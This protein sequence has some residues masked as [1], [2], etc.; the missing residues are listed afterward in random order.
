MDS[1]SRFSP[2]ATWVHYD[3]AMLH[4]HAGWSDHVACSAKRAIIVSPA[5]DLGYALL[6]RAQMEVGAHENAVRSFMRTT[7]IV[8]LPDRSYLE[9][10]AAAH[11]QLRDV[12]PA[13]TI[14]RPLILQ[15]PANLNTLSNY[16]VACHYAG[17][18]QF[19][20]R[21]TGWC[22]VIRPDFAD[23]YCNQ[24]LV[25]RMRGDVVTA[26]A[27]F[28]RSIELSGG[29]SFDIYTRGVFHLAEGDPVQGAL[30]YNARWEIRG[31]STSRNLYPEPSLPLP[32]WD[33]GVQRGSVLALWGEQGVGDEIWFS[34]FIEAIRDRVG[35]IR[36]EVTPHLV[37][38][39][40]RSFPAITVLARG[41][42][43]TET[44]MR[45]ADLQCP[46]GNLLMILAAERAEPGYLSVDQKRA[47]RLRERYRAAG[48]GRRLVGVSWRSVKP[49][50]G[51]RS[52]EAP[53]DAWGA[54]FGLPDTTFV[55]LQYGDVTKD[56]RLVRDRFG[57][58][59]LVD[60]EIDGKADLD[61]FAAQMAAMDAVVSVANASV[62]VAHGLNKP[63]YVAL[64]LLQEDWRYSRSRDP[65]RWM[66]TARQ[67]WQTRKGEWAP[68][69]DAQ[70]ARLA[71]EV[72]V[73]DTG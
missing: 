57:V 25:A 13:I 68:V 71:G 23:A 10:L 41:D 35:E 22:L 64:Q 58:D 28:D 1:A 51:T 63:I 31:F 37:S 38:L 44:A 61:G 65:S 16:S 70:A 30:D 19:A 69:L 60:S 14:L 15:D 48:D 21:Y 40:R 32:L 43:G 33:G 42:K 17:D 62:S 45:S 4:R 67:A 24:G 18:L 53:L 54:V 7:H 59:L 66:P 5:F 2:L 11:V 9:N 12:E 26:K 39:L 27:A 56:Q 3:L 6:G 36:L 50:R 29:R 8:H 47:S 52:F 20:E 73:A 34:G 49:G 46:I 72:G 55:S